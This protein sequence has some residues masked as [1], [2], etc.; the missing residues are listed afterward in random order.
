VFCGQVL[1]AWGMTEMSPLGTSCTLKGKHLSLPRAHQYD[2]LYKQGR[3]IYGVDMMLLVRETQS[4]I[5][6][7]IYM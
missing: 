2:V 6:I 3:A 5:S 1:H 4:H 7:N